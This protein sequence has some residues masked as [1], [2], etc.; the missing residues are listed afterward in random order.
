MKNS[1]VKHLLCQHCSEDFWI[2]E[3][4]LLKHEHQ[5]RYNPYNQ[6]CEIC[7]NFMALITIG[8]RGNY[9]TPFCYKSH[10]I[11][12][13]LLIRCKDWIDDYLSPPEELFW[14][15]IIKKTL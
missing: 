6:S 1:K 9:E 2:H 3:E 13:N 8:A 14:E 11:S 7:G 4:D 10:D 12:E 5:C 15:K